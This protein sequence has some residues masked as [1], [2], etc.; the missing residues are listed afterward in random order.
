[1]HGLQE[2]DWRVAARCLRLAGLPTVACGP[3]VAQA[4]EEHGLPVIATIANGVDPDGLPW[5][6]SAVEREWPETVGRSLLV[7]VG[8]LVTAKN[9]ELI[10]EA[11]PGVS[12]T[13]LVLVGD[14]PRRGNLEAEARALGVADRVVFAGN[15]SDARDILGA[16]DAAVFSSRAEGLPL[17]LLE[18]LH[19][20]RP[21]VATSVRGLRDVL[22]HEQTALLVGPDDPAALG[23]AINRVLQDAAL[24]GRLSAGARQL[25]GR[26]TADE[27]TARYSDLYRRLARSR[28]D[29]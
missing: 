2:A 27:M 19:A 5:S 9:H 23:A 16:A 15:R 14:G 28:H 3:G 26:F 24:R 22:T 11:L 6:R 25:A 8:R 12:D 13:T 10:V 1:V 7:S 20:G 21:I 17:A 29:G 4:L 18:A